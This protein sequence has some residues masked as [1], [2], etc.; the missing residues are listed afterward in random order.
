[1]SWVDN[2]PNTTKTIVNHTESKHSVQFNNE[3]LTSGRVSGLRI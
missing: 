3:P 1:M 2:N